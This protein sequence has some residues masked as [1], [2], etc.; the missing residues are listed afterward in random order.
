MQSKVKCQRRSHTWRR[1]FGSTL[2]VLKHNYHMRICGSSPNAKM[3]HFLETL[4]YYVEP[5]NNCGNL[6][7]G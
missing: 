4:K 5:D 2:G 6:R 7:Q 1:W 3:T